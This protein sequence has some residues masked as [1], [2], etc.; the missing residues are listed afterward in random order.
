MDAIRALCYLIGS[1]IWD[2]NCSN[3]IKDHNP[4]LTF[5]ST[6]VH[7]KRRLSPRLGDP[8]EGV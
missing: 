2:S 8:I 1:M 4:T 5:L 7:Y 6:C 3:R